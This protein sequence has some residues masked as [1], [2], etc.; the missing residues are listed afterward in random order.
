MFKKFE[1]QL[2][3]HKQAGNCCFMDR[4]IDHPKVDVKLHLYEY[5][6]RIYQAHQLL[7]D[8]TWLRREDVMGSEQRKEGRWNYRHLLFSSKSF[9]RNFGNSVGSSSR[10][11]SRNSL[12]EARAE[13][14]Q[15][16]I[17]DPIKGNFSAF[18]SVG[19]K[20]FRSSRWAVNLSSSLVVEFSS[21]SNLFRKSTVEVSQRSTSYLRWIALYCIEDNKRFGRSDILRAEGATATELQSI[22]QVFVPLDHLYA[23]L[24]H[25][26]YYILLFIHS[27]KITQLFLKWTLQVEGVKSLKE[28]VVRAL[29]IKDIQENNIFYFLHDQVKSDRNV[30]LERFSRKSSSGRD[31]EKDC[32]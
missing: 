1:S 4:N 22:L 12:S 13:I 32:K 28:A 6:R 19:F 29:E 18:G 8:K 25:S 10:R 30:Q 21:S 27:L 11:G 14:C 5:Q 2:F 7:F 9:G 15:I 3:I 23:L 16:N 20:K 24:P 26:I 31:G 17:E